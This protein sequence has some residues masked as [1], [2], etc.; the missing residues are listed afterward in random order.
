MH[1]EWLM[2]WKDVLLL[3]SVLYVYCLC[4]LDFWMGGSLDVRLINDNLVGGD[5]LIFRAFRILFLQFTLQ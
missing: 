1:A 3:Q 5:K 2:G 4:Q